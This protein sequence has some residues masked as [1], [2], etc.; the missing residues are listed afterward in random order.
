[1]SSFWVSNKHKIN[2]ATELFERRGLSTVNKQIQKTY[3]THRKSHDDSGIF[4]GPAGFIVSDGFCYDP[5]FQNIADNIKDDLESIID[6][7][8][9]VNGDYS[10]YIETDRYC[11]VATDPWKTKQ[12]FVSIE[13]DGSFCVS[14]LPDMIR[15]QKKHAYPV[16]ANT[17]IVLD[18]KDHSVRKHDIKKW[19]LTQHVTNHNAVF[20]ALNE[21]VEL[22]F[23]S[24]SISTLSSG[25]DSGVIAC[26]LSNLGHKDFSLGFINTEDKQV[27]A[28]RCKIHKGKF[29]PELGQLSDVETKDLKSLYLQEEIFSEAGEAIAR[30]CKYM[31]KTGKSN[32][33]SGNGGDEMYSDY[34]YHGR[35]LANHS[36]FGGHFP[37]VLDIIWPWHE[38]THRQSQLVS[39]VDLLGGYYGVQHKEPLLD[40]NLVQ[41][42][43]NT[44]QDLKNK[45]YKNWM[46]EYMKEHEYP[47][48]EN[49]KIGFAGPERK[50]AEINE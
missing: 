46:Y 5:G 22:R 4:I 12:V 16:G 48:S 36:L 24:Q 14:S 26:A 27:L 41:A 33:L 37:A 6:L 34:G 9:T 18:K 50:L 3:I 15:M 35:Q 32:I 45:R 44:T 40:I 20:D 2:N 39:R 28:Q 23:D 7:L 43:L 13:D 19:D 8:N 42:W 29:L 31:N 10:L 47:I 25:Y 21:S 1:M 30:V 11:A 38:Y 49:T 17:L